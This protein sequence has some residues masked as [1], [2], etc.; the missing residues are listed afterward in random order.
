MGSLSSA[1]YTM[2]L[3]A[4]RQYARGPLRLRRAVEGGKARVGRTP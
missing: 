1:G 2:L 4:K 3:L